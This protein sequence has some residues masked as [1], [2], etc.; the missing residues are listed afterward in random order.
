MLCSFIYL[1]G[2]C[3]GTNPIINSQLSRAITFYIPNHLKPLDAVQVL[4]FQF[5]CTTHLKVLVVRD[6]R[7]EDKA[8][9]ITFVYDDDITPDLDDESLTILVVLVVM[10]MMMT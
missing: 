7:I 5:K 9:D 6:M 4:A 2:I 3:H 8:D 10:M 1:T